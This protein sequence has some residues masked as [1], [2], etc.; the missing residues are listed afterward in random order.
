MNSFAVAS[1]FVAVMVMTL[2]LAGTPAFAATEPL[3]SQNPSRISTLDGLRGFL[4]LAVLCHHG[5]VYRSFLQT[6]DWSAVPGVGA[7]LGEGGVSMFFM[8]TG[9]LFWRR[10]IATGGRPDWFKL[11]VGRMFRIGPLYLLAV[12]TA[13]FATFAA[14][15]ERIVSW[16]ALTG[17]IAPYFALGL[18]PLHDVNGFATPLL[19]AK[20]TWSLHYEW[21]FYL[22]LP[23]L[24][25]AAR[26]P[27][28]HALAPAAMLIVSFWLLSVLRGTIED[29]LVPIC[30]A[31]FAL[32]MLS[33]SAQAHGSSRDGFGRLGSIGVVVLAVVSVS[34]FS[35]AYSRPAMLMLGALFF[36]VA[37][38]NSVFGLLTSRSAVRLG[39]ISYGIYLLQ[40]LILAA[41]FR[42]TPLRA[43]ALGSP[44][45]HGALLLLSAILLVIVAA[46]A[47]LAVERRGIR[48]GQALVAWS[49]T[50]RPL[51]TLSPD[52][53]EPR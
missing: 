39:E 10:L 5:V 21:L 44:I 18:L 17:Q 22:S 48:L 23:L 4:A 51:V 20:V 40:G 35:T 2:A 9:Y 8:L 19:L 31:L 28:L 38:G 11:Y 50:R 47:H 12:A 43:L 36:L 7:M 6:Q 13:L 49:A 41:V 34:C 46:L 53:L 30:A 26:S 3:R 15:P 29:K 27:R 45:W 52:A 16:Q 25:F 24:G 32:G 1:C 33:A 42:P 14:F 37:S